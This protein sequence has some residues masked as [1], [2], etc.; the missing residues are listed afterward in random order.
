[1]ASEEMFNWPDGDVIIRATHGTDT[2]D[3]RVHKCFLSFSSPIF[4]DMFMIP[5]PPSTTPDS[6]DVV[7]V[8][9][10][11]RALELILRFIYPSIASP[12]VDDLAVFSETYVLADKYDI[13]VA[14]ARL[15]SA[16]AGFTKT[17]PLRAYG[18]ACRFGLKDEMKAASSHTMSI[19]LPTL[20]ELPDEFKFVPATEYHRLIRLHF[21][22]RKEVETIVGLTN[23]VG[24]DLSSSSLHERDVAR[25]LRIRAKGREAAKQHLKRCIREGWPLNSESLATALKAENSTANFL[26]AEIQSHVSS[27]LSRADGLK[28][29]I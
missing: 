17:E 20:A 13:E 18:I 22:Y 3:F 11:P 19:H 26:D 10:P 5:Q 14:R 25:R 8:G 1:M 27:I 2:R 9:D 29:A 15:R 12:V 4:K 21:K 23:F 16:F 7:A 24:P 28:L 6:V